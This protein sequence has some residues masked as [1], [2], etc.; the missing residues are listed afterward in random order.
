MQNLT[1]PENIFGNRTEKD[2]LLSVVIPAYN[3][4]TRIERSLIPT[5]TYLSQASYCN[6][7]IVVSDGSEDRTV[8]VAEKHQN[9]F[10]SLRVIAYHPNAGKGKA[11]RTGVLASEG[12]YILFMD[13]DYSVPIEYVAEFLQVLYSGFDIA[14]GSRA[15]RGSQ[16][17]A[18]QGLLRQTAG[19]VH[20][21]VQRTVLGLKIKDTQCGFKM[22]KSSVALELFQEQKL[23]GVLFD[24]EVLYLGVRKG[25]HVKEIPVQWTHDQR[26]I[27]RYNV[28][29]SIRVFRE[30]FQIRRMH[31]D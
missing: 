14:I 5:I 21:A 13:A 9:Q 30:L 6:E 24:C 27:I 7:I 28:R 12:Q 23:D 8:A 15:Y 10:E 25:L 22:F 18:G 1:S 11:V 29:N 3:E 31:P 20:G 19:K 2:L 26:S 17:I 16:I 4:E